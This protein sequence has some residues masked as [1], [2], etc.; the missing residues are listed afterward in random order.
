M[1]VHDGRYDRGMKWEYKTL[2]LT[3]NGL[4]VPKVDT[5][6]VDAEFDRLGHDGWGLVSTFDTN[7]G[8]GASYQMVAILKRSRD[9]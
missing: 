9:A 4:M 7:A 3:T 8:L 6:K 5:A 2:C 1:H